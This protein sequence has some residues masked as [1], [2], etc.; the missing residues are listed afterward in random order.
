[1]ALPR[2]RFYNLPHVPMRLEISESEVNSGFAVLLN[3]NDL[4]LLTVLGKPAQNLRNAESDRP[5][6]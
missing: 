2:V 3:L 6:E 4:W 1:V 5:D